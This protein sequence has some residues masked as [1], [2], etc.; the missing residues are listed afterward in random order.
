MADFVKQHPDAPPGYFAWE[1][2]GLQWLS[3][4]DGGVPCAQVV[5]VDESAL[6][7][8]RLDSVP[9]SPE[10][11]RVFGGRLAV[12]HDAGAPAFGAGPE[13][14]EGPGFFG[15]LVAAVADVAAAAPALG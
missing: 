10:A 15:P 1:A 6:T 7:L 5:A 14:W 12:T 4:V 3:S 9:P 2:A 13:G 8:R 11:A